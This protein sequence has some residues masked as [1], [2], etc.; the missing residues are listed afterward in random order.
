[1]VGDR[2]DAFVSIAGSFWLTRRPSA[3][4]VLRNPEWSRH[5]PPEKVDARSRFF[6]WLDALLG[7]LAARYS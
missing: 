3:A 4:R 5:L 7:W 1:M 6:G 2:A